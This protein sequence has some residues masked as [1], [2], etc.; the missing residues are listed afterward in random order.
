MKDE[1]I[2]QAYITMFLEHFVYSVEELEKMG[3]TKE[4]RKQNLINILNAFK[5]LLNKN[6]RLN[7]GD[8][9][10][11]GNMVNDGYDIP[12]GIRKIAVTAGNKARWN[13]TEPPKIYQELY[14]LIDNYCN[15]W[16]GLDPY[17]K[18]A[19]F[20]IKYMHIHPFEDGNKR[21]GKLIMASNMWKAGITPAVITDADTD[22]YYE[23]LN[24]MDDD[25]FA[26][27]LKQRSVN[28]TSIMCAFYKQCKGLGLTDEVDDE[29]V[30]K[31]ILK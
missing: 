14:Y 11:V 31:L 10:K 13:P 4:Q 29:K 3:E 28:E 20:H 23:L 8:I 16:Y 27:F 12:K 25:R 17:L 5:Y 18:E 19:K 7:I 22:I 26:L 6:D 21:S 15:N 24:K 9:I 30:K 2:K 1:E